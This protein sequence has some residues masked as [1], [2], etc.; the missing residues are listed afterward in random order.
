[1]TARRPRTPSA[2]LLLLLLLP[3]GLA[4]AE[5]YLAI[6]A[7]YRCSTCHVNPTGGGLRSQFGTLFSQRILPMRPLSAD[8][9][10]WSG[11]LTQYLRVGADLRA[12]WNRSELPGGPS[13]Q[14]ARV[15]QLR[16]YAQA[17]PIPG[18]L[19]LNVDEALAPGRARALEA[20]ARLDLARH[21]LY[22]KGG[23]FYLPF[24][25]RLQD[26]AALVREVSGISMTEADK[27]VEAGFDG[28]RW[29]A[30]LDYT[31][32]IANAGS[33]SGH[34][35]TGQ[36][37]RVLDRWRVG[38]SFTHVTTRAGNRSVA[39]LFGGL[40]SGDVAWLGEADV[41]SDG[42]YPE[43]T[44]HLL[45][46][47]AEADWRIGAGQNLKLTAEYHDPDRAIAQDERLR[48]SL[49]YELT[50]LPFVQLRAGARRYR[51]IPQDD[52]DNRRQFF[53]ELHAW[54]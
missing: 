10:G 50:P 18:W 29:G 49:V 19:S 44:R 16:A 1:M 48:W 51:G 2:L 12:A 39:G 22:I 28:E 42:G 30:A 54:L 40:R 4:H 13:Q 41:I 17:T 20:Y 33:G 43:G 36:L 11:T 8:A 25:W 23:Q 34:Q 45:A 6:Q 26:Q 31:R 37:V 47:L 46:G 52:F 53:L 14:H 15:D 5:P 9:N 7:G 27:G 35:L 3:A 24:G 21:G 38:T 32:G